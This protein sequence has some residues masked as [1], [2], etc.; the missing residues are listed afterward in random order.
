MV[1]QSGEDND[2]AARPRRV[3]ISYAHE[4]GNSEHGEVVRAFWEFLRS[5]GIDAHIDLIAAEQ[6]QD[7]ALWMADEIRAAD[8][9]LVIASPTYRERAEGHSDPAVG[10]GVQWEARLIRDAFYDN[11]HALNRFVPVVLPGQT[12]QGVPD[13]LAPNSSTV[14][15]VSELTVAGA[16]SLLRL[17]TG[18]PAEIEPPLGPVPL[19]PPRAIG[20]GSAPTTDASGEP[21]RP[22][23]TILNQVNGTRT[24]PV[25]Q[26]GTID[27]LVIH[28]PATGAAA[29]SLARGRDYLAA[30]LRQVPHLIV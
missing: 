10:K 16:E 26:A 22:A 3:F 6:R 1:G 4:P 20:Q 19:L 11:Q 28:Q 13:F 21:D 9:V 8:Y 27:S 30:Y 25:I 17:L 29:P 12:T 15:E 5:H 7:W 2:E 24:G 23:P 14:Y 18:Q